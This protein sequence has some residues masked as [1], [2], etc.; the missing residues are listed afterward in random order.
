MK[1]AI[2]FID[3]ILVGMGL[4][5]LAEMEEYSKTPDKSNEELLMRI[6]RDNENTEYGKKYGFKDIHSIEEYREKV[7]FSKYDNYAPYIQRMVQ[8][9]E[10]NLITAYDVICTSQ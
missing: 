3:S 10:T 9:K 8:N 1:P 5:T 7:P 4:Q 6:L 2:V